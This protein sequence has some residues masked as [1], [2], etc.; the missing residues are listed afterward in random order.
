M[1][2]YMRKPVAINL[3]VNEITVAAMF[4]RTRSFQ[5]RSHAFMMSAGGGSEK[6]VNQDGCRCKIRGRGYVLFG[7][8]LRKKESKLCVICC[9]Y[10]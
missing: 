8:K 1:A 2:T 5:L 9:Y 7:R 6:Y 10:A 4:Y 3:I